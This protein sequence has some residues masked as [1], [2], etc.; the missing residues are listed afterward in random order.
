MVHKFTM[1]FIMF[2]QVQE[3]FG[4]AFL[5]ILIN[6][7]ENIQLKLD[8]SCKSMRVFQNE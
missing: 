7:G 8:Y 4:T 6:I 2:M 5:P 1:S 3:T